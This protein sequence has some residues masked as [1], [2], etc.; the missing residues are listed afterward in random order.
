MT[1]S[2]VIST[3]GDL[4][5]TIAGQLSTSHSVCCPFPWQILSEEVHLVIQFLLSTSKQG[6]GGCLSGCKVFLCN[7]VSVVLLEF[8]A[9]CLFC[10]SCYP[11]IHYST[12]FQNMDLNNW[13]FYR[14]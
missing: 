11:W 12:T 10:A 4:G 7:C 9:Y 6:V 13:R 3:G 5:K 1:R 14:I 2:N 8:F